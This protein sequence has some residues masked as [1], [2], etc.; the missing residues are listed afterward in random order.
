MPQDGF[1]VVVATVSSGSGE[2]LWS[3]GEKVWISTS[4]T[5]RN[6]QVSAAVAGCTVYFFKCSW[7]PDLSDLTETNENSWNTSKQLISICPGHLQTF[8][9]SQ[10]SEC[11]PWRVREPYLKLS[12]LQDPYIRTWSNL[13]G[14]SHGF[15]CQQQF[16]SKSFKSHC[17]HCGAS[18]HQQPVKFIRAYL[19]LGNVPTKQNRVSWATI[20]FLIGVPGGPGQMLCRSSLHYRSGLRGDLFQ[21]F[22]RGQGYYMA[23]MFGVN[24]RLIWLLIIII[25]N[26][27]NNVSG[28]PV[29]AVLCLSSVSEWSR[30]RG[31][32]TETIKW[33]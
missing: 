7:S 6:V 22:G 2:H 8:V 17:G 27:D 14:P 16:K 20:Q 28:L 15:G 13:L 4:C 32:F 9:H 18:Q 1:S 26:E 33:S 19:D 25:W 5:V 21:G 31:A 23:E 30:W 12:L 24:E 10:T 29:R 11:F 3:Y